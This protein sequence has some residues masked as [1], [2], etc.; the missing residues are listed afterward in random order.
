[1][2]ILINKLTDI[3]KIPDFPEN[4][5]S[6]IFPEIPDTFPEPMG[7]PSEWSEP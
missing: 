5:N 1:M 6:G 3:S 7:C 2:L 4:V